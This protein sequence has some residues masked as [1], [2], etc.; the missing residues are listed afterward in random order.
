MGQAHEFALDGRH[1]VFVGDLGVEEAAQRF[2]SRVL[3]HRAERGLTAW[4]GKAFCLTDCAGGQVVVLSFHK[5]GLHHFV[6]LLEN[7][8]PG[9]ILSQRQE[10]QGRR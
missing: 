7:L 1:G 2:E 4:Q 3:G 9:A 10:I 6:E 5:V 8:L